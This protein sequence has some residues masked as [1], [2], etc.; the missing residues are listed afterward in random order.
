M[1]VHEREYEV[2]VLDLCEHVCAR[3]EQQCS[4]REVKVR[5]CAAS[6]VKIR[7]CTISV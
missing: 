2:L 3:E 6:L 4:Q 1:D 7:K 5:T